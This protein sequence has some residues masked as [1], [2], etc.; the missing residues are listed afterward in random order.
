LLGNAPQ[1]AAQDP[2]TNSPQP[3][4]TEADTVLRNLSLAALQF[5]HSDTTGSSLVAG[6]LTTQG[7]GVGAGLKPEDVARGYSESVRALDRFFTAPVY[8]SSEVIGE[9]DELDR[10][11]ETAQVRQEAD[12]A[13]VDPDE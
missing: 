7:Q 6:G 8:G 11:P 1:A 3:G 13:L 4:I 5:A 10:L 12:V 2:S 9:Q